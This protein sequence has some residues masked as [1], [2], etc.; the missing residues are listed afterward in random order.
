MDLRCLNEDG[1]TM[2]HSHLITIYNSIR[3]IIYCTNSMKW[4]LVESGPTLI[5]S[6]SLRVPITVEIIEHR[7]AL[8]DL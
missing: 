8:G 7:S 4:F 2:Y 1:L 5:Q 6:Q 3:E